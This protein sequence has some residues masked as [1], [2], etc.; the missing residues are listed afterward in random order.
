MAIG[1]T[2]QF[3]KTYSE[4]ITYSRGE[5]N[6]PAA[7]VSL[8]AQSCPRNRLRC[9]SE[10]IRER[11][12][13]VHC[14]GSWAST[15]LDRLH[16]DSEFRRRDSSE[17]AIGDFMAVIEAMSTESKEHRAAEARGETQSMAGVTTDAKDAPRTDVCPPLAQNFVMFDMSALTATMLDETKVAILG[18]DV[19]RNELFQLIALF[20]NEHIDKRHRVCLDAERQRREKIGKLSR[21]KDIEEGITILVPFCAAG[22]M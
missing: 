4:F 8:T 1:V 5:A 7:W 3:V 15:C 2:C 10:I 19:R 13:I 14:S 11:R 20:Q 12:F 17:F 22:T 18:E 21:G 16:G 6:L 9:G